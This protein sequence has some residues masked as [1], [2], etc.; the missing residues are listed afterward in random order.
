M[1]LLFLQ[2]VKYT[3]YYITTEHGI[4]N[5]GWSHLAEIRVY[6]ILVLFCIILYLILLTEQT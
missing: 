1:R 2:F 5:I 4:W 3:K 6:L